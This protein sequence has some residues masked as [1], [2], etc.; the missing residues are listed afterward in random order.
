MRASSLFMCRENLFHPATA[1]QSQNNGIC[2]WIIHTSLCPAG[3]QRFPLSTEAARP[4]N[5]YV[6]LISVRMKPF[7]Q[8]TVNKLIFVRTL[9]FQHVNIYSLF[10]ILKCWGS[11]VSL[12][13]QFVCFSASRFV[14]ALSWW[15]ESFYFLS[16]PPISETDERPEDT[17]RTLRSVAISTHGANSISDT[18][19]RAPV[20]LYNM[21]GNSQLC[22]FAVYLLQR[23][24]WRMSKRLKDESN[25]RGICQHLVSI[26]KKK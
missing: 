6:L 26:L 13:Q 5:L 24:T 10:L 12:Y 19:L 2:S 1:Q 11:K 7:F 18:L 4:S 20:A 9:Y 3:H 21:H 23:K 14:T 25:I 8:N 15:S 17:A 22:G 16:S